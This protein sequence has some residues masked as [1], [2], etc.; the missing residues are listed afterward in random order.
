M[1]KT[2]WK[3]LYEVYE[4][5]SFSDTMTIGIIDVEIAELLLVPRRFCD[6]VQHAL[7]SLQITEQQQQNLQRNKEKL[8]LSFFMLL[9]G[10]GR[11][12]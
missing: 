4:I 8:H 12:R 6:G 1:L 2:S 3:S 9:N 11:N 10:S 5:V 7:I